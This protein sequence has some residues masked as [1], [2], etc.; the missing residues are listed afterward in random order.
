MCSWRGGGGGGGGRTW[1]GSDPLIRELDLDAVAARVPADL[2]EPSQQEHT[3]SSSHQSPN[4]APEVHACTGRGGR[5]TFTNTVIIRP[6]KQTYN[7]T[8]QVDQDP[9]L[10]AFL[11]KGCG[12]KR[13]KGK[14]CYSLFSQ[15]HYESMRMQCRELSRDKLDLVIL[16][17]IAALLA[18]TSNTIAPKPLPQ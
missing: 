4:P 16:A 7:V 14:P 2:L 8:T 1:H 5:G 13:S 17:Q 9:D 12:C 11:E 10:S 15:D 6:G 18:H 3:P